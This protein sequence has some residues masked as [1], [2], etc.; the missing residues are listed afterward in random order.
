MATV[1][2]ARMASTTAATK[3]DSSASAV[4]LPSEIPLRL[5]IEVGWGGGLSEHCVVPETS[6][7]KLPDNVSMEVGGR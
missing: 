1:V 7:Y 6:L 3:M 2:R 4:R 5:L